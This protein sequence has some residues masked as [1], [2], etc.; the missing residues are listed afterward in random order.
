MRIIYH[1]NGY[2]DE[3]V[4]AEVFRDLLE[5]DLQGDRTTGRLSLEFTSELRERIAGCDLRLTLV[6]HSIL[7][8]AVVSES[9]KSG[10]RI[11][12]FKSDAYSV[13]C[14]SPTACH[15]LPWSGELKFVVR[16]LT[17][18]IITAVYALRQ[19][20]SFATDLPGAPLYIN[21]SEP[22]DA[23][24]R[25]G[26]VYC[27]HCKTGFEKSS[28]LQWNG[29]RHT[30]CQQRL[31]LKSVRSRTLIENVSGKCVFCGSDLL[32]GNATCDCVPMHIR[33]GT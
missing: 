6:L 14:R 31:V 5:S 21:E 13:S 17:H 2:G 3:V 32:L 28:V 12:C 27:P 33:D 16:N 26:I 22:L 11:Q 29:E 4:S 9:F 20:K 7:D 15:K 24:V 25:D 10:I 1:K 30:F 19:F 8:I 18:A 23:D